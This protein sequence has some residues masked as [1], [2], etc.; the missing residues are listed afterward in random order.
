MVV[1]WAGVLGGT[2]DLGVDPVPARAACVLRPAAR[3]PEHNVSASSCAT[4]AAASARRSSRCARTCASCWP[5]ARCRRALKWIEDRREN[6]MSAGPG[7][8]RRR[9]RSRMAFDDDGNILAADIDFVQDVGAYPTPYPVLTTAAVGMFFPGP[10][11]VPKAS[12]NYKTV[13]SNTAGLAAYR[14]P[15]QF[16]T[17]APR[18][19]ARHRGA[20]DGHR[21]RRA[22][23]PQPPARRRA[24]VRQPQRHA[25]RPRRARGD[26]RAGGEDPRL[27]GLP[28]G[29][30]RRAGAGP[31]PRRRLLGLRRADGAATGH[32][33]TEG[34]TIRIEPT[35]KVN[36][37]VNGGSTGNSIETTVVQLTA[38]ALGA[39]IDDV[40]TIQGDTAV[41]PYGAGTQGSR[42]GSMTAGAVNEAG[43]ILRKQI[44]AIA[45]HRLERRR[46]DIELAGSRASRPRRPRRRA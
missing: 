9:R 39:D 11:R 2:H 3:H 37:Y 22:A 27:R 18:D 44:V 24:A 17:L 31:L 4:P 7:P 43:T 25:V 46:S 29:A 20:Q 14:G 15:W 35:G 40:D 45:A 19:P 13:F 6:L 10:Y 23:P 16:E 38:D 36:V 32:L 42:S 5:P 41:T 21:P 26:V 28:Q 33:G 34:A 12:F 1:E 30:G 8:P